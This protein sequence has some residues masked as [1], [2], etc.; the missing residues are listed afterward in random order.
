MKNITIVLA[1][2]ISSLSFGQMQ[3]NAYAKV[4][5]ISGVSLSCSH[6]DE[7]NDSF[8]LG[9]VIMVYQVQDDVLGGNANNNSSFGDVADIRSAG[10]V[11]FA[12][13][14]SITKTGSN[15]TIELTELLDESFSITSNKSIQVV[16]FPTFTDYTTTDD[17]IAKAWDGHIGGVVA[18][19]VAGRLTLLHNISADAAGFQ[20]GQP[21]K[22]SGNSCDE[23]T[24]I[25]SN[26]NYGAKGES[27]YRT[28]NSNLGNGKGKI[29][30]GGGGGNVH[31]GGGAGGSNFTAG[32]NG[33][34][35]WLC[36]IGS[37]GIPGLNLSTYILANENRMVFGG[38]A[39]GGQQNNSSATRGGNGGGLVFIKANEIYVSSN[40]PVISSNGEDG[41]DTYNEGQDGAGGGGAGGS[42]ALI[43]DN[44]VFDNAGTLSVQANGG[45]G[46]NV[47]H[48]DEHGSGGGGGA[49]A[50]KFFRA[51]P[52]DY[53]ELSSRTDAGLAGRR[54]NNS[55]PFATGEGESGN[56]TMHYFEFGRD[57]SSLLPVEMLQMGVECDENIHRIFWTTASESNNEYFLIEASNEADIWMILESVAGAGNSLTYNDYE[58]INP[59]ANYD[60]YRISQTDFDGTREY[61]EILTADCQS[62]LKSLEISSLYHDGN[63]LQIEFKGLHSGNLDVQIVNNLARPVFQENISVFGGEQFLSLPID[64]KTGIYIVRISQNGKQLSDKII[65]R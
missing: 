40:A 55:Q 56:G 12:E 60:Y 20:G 35:G 28:N 26:S 29:A 10:L 13:I 47:I 46:G 52:L 30:N 18:F 9:D 24:F 41:P 16:S 64:F 50:I 34:S 45:N 11:E 8:D 43:V 53:S 7:A 65:I 19:H 31:N 32:G 61:F 22:D 57:L 2:L 48:V 36:T 62:D 42:V 38:G 25:T 23:G 44:Y 54:S 3:V 14:A 51:D 63:S 33:G 27:I 5:T 4:N 21:S 58:V 39:G 37:G 17:I 59:K 1:I 6:L 15:M 49:G